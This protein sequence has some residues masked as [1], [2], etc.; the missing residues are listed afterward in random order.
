MASGV[1]HTDLAAIRDARACP[2]VLGH[3][4]AGVVESV[5]ADVIALCSGDHVVINWQPRCATC[6]A[7]RT[8]R[9]QYCTD[10]RGTAGARLHLNGKPLSVMLQSGTF[11]PLAVVPAAGA[12]R[13]RDDIPFAKAALLGCAVA[14]GVGAALYTARVQEG[15]VVV[16]IGAGGVGLNVIQA[17][18]MLR[19]RAIVAVDLDRRRLDV[20]RQY[21]ATA[22][23][24]PSANDMVRVVRQAS[25]GLGA[26]H[27]FEVVGRIETMSTALEVLGRGGVLT[28]VGAAARDAELAF[29]PRAFMSNQQRIQGCI[30]GD[31]DPGRDLPMFADWYMSE[32]LQLAA[33]HTETISLDQ[34]PALF[35]GTRPR[36]GVRTVVSMEGAW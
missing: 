25:D 33:L 17:C 24:D 1:C 7:C 32:R 13:V 9:P 26:D 30:Y 2:I 31:V 6:R 19:A 22:C 20:A 3:E 29:G 23:V 28:L 8:G 36:V 4:G 16:V 27:A 34:V 12:V 15:D 18:R 11:C 14:T 35:E 5:G 10:V 21:G